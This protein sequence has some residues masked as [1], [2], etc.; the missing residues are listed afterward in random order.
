MK[1]DTVYSVYPSNGNLNG[2]KLT[3]MMIKVYKSVRFGDTLCS[4]K[5]KVGKQKKTGFTCHKRP[6]L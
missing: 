2:F 3:A 6:S 4:D 5:L 1:M